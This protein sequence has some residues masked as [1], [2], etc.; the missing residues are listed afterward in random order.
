[1]P[2]SVLLDNVGRDEDLSLKYHLGKDNIGIV[3][4]MNFQR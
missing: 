4:D 2:Y 1:M 3:C